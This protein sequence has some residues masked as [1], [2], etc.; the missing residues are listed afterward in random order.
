MLR[1]KTKSF[2]LTY[3]ALVLSFLNAISVRFRKTVLA[4]G[5]VIL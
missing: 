2:F 5:K 1:A 3:I 4:E